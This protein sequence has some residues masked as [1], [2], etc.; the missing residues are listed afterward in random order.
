M[1]LLRF[2]YEVPELDNFRL[3]SLKMDP[4]ELSNINL[5]VG[6]NASGKSSIVQHIVSLADMLKGT[7]LRIGSYSLELKDDDGSI[8]KYSCNI[9]LGIKSEIEISESLFI[10]ADQLVDRKNNIA[11][12]Y[13]AIKSEKIEI[14]PPENK[15]VHQVRRDE[16][17]YPYFEKLIK[18]A[19]SVHS[20]KFGH[21]HSTSF[22]KSPLDKSNIADTGL[23]SINDN[24]LNKILGE[25][26]THSKNEVIKE[27]N[28]LG[29]NIEILTV[30]LQ[31]EKNIIYVKENNVKYEIS[32]TMLS[33][34]M[35]RSLFLLIFVH[36]LI[37][38]E[39]AKMII[40]DDLCES[41]DY[42]RATKLGKLL[43]DKMNTNNVQFI[44]TS[45]DSFL[46]NVIDIKYWNI[47]YREA[48]F[49]KVYNYSNSK[50]KF[51]K[52]RRS[53]FNNFDLLTSNYL[54]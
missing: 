18:W 49:I 44:A 42:D 47:I 5:L 36:H 34:G 27:F 6:K 22:M 20:F 38:S 21:I 26:N 25:L 39:K 7:N 14:N 43:F 29:Y 10:N 12:I 11:K 45:N 46:M 13:S 17:D 48:N 33:Q 41:L 23:T 37:D 51:D 32:Q 40:I 31:A 16:K 28:S 1:K 50:E 15:L 52:F 3:N 2:F 35:W 30:K 8:L 24:D 9:S 54:N 4:I 53:G 19:E